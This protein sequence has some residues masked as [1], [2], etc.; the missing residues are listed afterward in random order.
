MGRSGTALDNAPTES[1]FATLK[2]ELIDG[3]TYRTRD[4]A[5][6]AIFGFIELFYNRRH[7]SLGYVSPDEYERTYWNRKEGSKAA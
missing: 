7:S 6:V 1:F 2:S 4:Q 3:R 5:R